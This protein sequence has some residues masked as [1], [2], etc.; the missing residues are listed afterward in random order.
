[1]ECSGRRRR[2]GGRLIRRHY[3]K[4]KGCRVGDRSSSSSSCLKWR[5]R[6]G[7]GPET[8]L[9]I[10][11]LDS[12]SA[13]SIDNDWL[14]PMPDGRIMA[15]GR[16]VSL[17]LRHVSLSVWCRGGGDSHLMK[18]PQQQQQQPS[19]SRAFQMWTWRIIVLEYQ[20]VNCRSSRTVN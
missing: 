11:N 13:A 20:V 18:Q 3:R 7:G 8:S 9:I 1:M 10:I 2:Q 17:E 5:C 16:L 12:I 4:G 15:G 6:R 14:C 19:L